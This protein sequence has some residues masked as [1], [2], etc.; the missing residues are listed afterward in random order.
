MRPHLKYCVQVWEPQHRKD[1]AV[2]VDPEEGH[3]DYQRAAAS[4]LQIEAEGAGLVHSGEE[5]APERPRH[6]L[7]VPEGSL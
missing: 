4:P 6:G 2:E 1:R 5:K 7:P 3:E